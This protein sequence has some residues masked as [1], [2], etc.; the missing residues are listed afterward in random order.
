MLMKEMVFSRDHIIRELNVDVE[1]LNSN[2]DA[3]ILIWNSAMDQ[4]GKR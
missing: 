2:K 3:K 4:V 1:F